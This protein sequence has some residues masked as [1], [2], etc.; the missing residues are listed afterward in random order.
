[1]FNKKLQGE[2]LKRIPRSSFL[3]KVIKKIFQVKNLLYSL[4]IKCIIFLFKVRNFILSQKPIEIEIDD[5]SFKVIPK[6]AGALDY[7]S[8]LRFEK[9]EL[10]FVFDQIQPKM[11]FLD[12][13]ANIGFFSLA[14]ASKCKDI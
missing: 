9:D 2:I 14:V 3:R 4:K 8:G 12:L 1:M 10:N 7:W 11:T 5:I 13:G 6:G